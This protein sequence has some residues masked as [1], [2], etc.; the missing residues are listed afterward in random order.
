MKLQTFVIEGIADI[1][2][3]SLLSWN[4]HGTSKAWDEDGRLSAEII[5]AKGELEGVSNYYTNSKLVQ[6]IPYSKGVIHGTFYEWYQDGLLRKEENFSM[7]TRE[8]IAKGFWPSGKLAFEEVYK[9]DKL[10]TGLYFDMQG[11]QVG[12]ITN[13]CGIKCFFNDFGP[14]EYHEYKEGIPEGC[15][16]VLSEG[17]ILSVYYIK[18]GKKHGEELFYYPQSTPVAQTQK[19]L[20]INWKEGKISGLVKSWY[21]NGIQESQRELSQNFKQGLFT[22][23]YDDGSLMFLEE[24]EKD[25]LI[26]GEYLKKRGKYSYF[27]SN[28]R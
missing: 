21:P 27:Q 5:Y 11:I 10:L 23:W 6:Q 8:G 26:K 17:N 25:K 19:K 1:D 9:E 12:S 24:Y 13:G 7:G 15:V 4:F 28:L 2:E 22:A 18:D 16:T 3:K 20:S 14:K